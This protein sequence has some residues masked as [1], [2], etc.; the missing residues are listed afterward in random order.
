MTTVH[1][2]DHEEISNVF[3]PV[4]KEHLYILC[5]VMYTHM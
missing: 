1:F 3:E 4:H 2:A 5:T